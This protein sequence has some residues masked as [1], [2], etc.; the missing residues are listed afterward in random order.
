MINRVSGISFTGITRIFAI[1]DS[2]Q[3]T[4]RTASFLSKI[5]QDKNADNNDV[6]LHCGDFYGGIYPS[7]LERDC[8]IKM[9]KVRPNLEMIMTIGNH[10]FGYDYNGFKFL[11]KTIKQF[12]KNGI[13][14][15][16]SNLTDPSGSNF[17][18]ILPYTVIERDGDKTLV[19][20]FCTRTLGKQ[21]QKY[22]KVTNQSQKIDE[23]VNA[24]EKEK[25]DNII[26]LNHDFL[27]TSIELIDKLKDRGIKIDLLIGGHD[28]RPVEA[29][30]PEHIYYP[31]VFSKEMHIFDIVNDNGKKELKLEEIIKN[32]DDK[33]LISPLFKPQIETFEEKE[34]LFK[35]LSKSVL[36]LIH[37]YSEPCSYGTFFADTVKEF[38][39]ADIGFISSGFIKSSLPYKKGGFITT[40]DLMQSMPTKTPV[41]TSLL[42]INE[43]KEVIS[44]ALKIRGDLNAGGN[45]R[46]LQFSNNVKIKGKR[47]FKEKRFD[48]EQ[49]YINNTPLLKNNG[50]PI[51]K[52]KTFKCAMDKFIASGG[53][54]FS[55]FYKKR[56]HP[57]YINGK[58]S[59]INE[60]LTAGIIKAQNL[61]KEGY[62]YPCFKIIEN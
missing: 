36:N 30:I 1:T 10:D 42:T 22:A 49:I 13:K 18:G 2:H 24:I 54:Q 53:Q 58:P 29:C 23:L 9:K 21:G 8:Y 50:E 3:E 5:L 44:H 56:C 26:I 59:K 4:R 39:N 34:K 46:F 37:I 55:T 43:L 45:P 16:C 41:Y 19:T 15:V 51:D 6:F 57:V 33:P 11:L 38:A 40:Y 17:E 62:E 27:D 52:K 20:G 12:N 31:A 61:Y 47:N 14:V 32:S 48:I 35:P 25:P 7:R 28:H 60:V